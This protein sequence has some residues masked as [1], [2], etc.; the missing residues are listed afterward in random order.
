MRK[1]LVAFVS[2]TTVGLFAAPS[3]NAA[4]RWSCEGADYV[5]GSSP[6]ATAPSYDASE[7]KTARSTKSAKAAPKQRRQETARANTDEDKPAR[8][9]TARASS[10]DGGGETLSGKASYYWQP[11]ALASGGRFNPNAYTAAHKTLPFGTRVRVTNQNN[12]QSVDVVI[13]DRGPYVAGRIIDLSKAAAGSINMQ[14][15]GVVP[16]SVR[17]LGRG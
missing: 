8:R 12:G 2:L 13:N 3:A 9:R 15:S 16:V 14:N 4:A 7:R 6:A 17:V 5:C 1:L 11:Q 10:G